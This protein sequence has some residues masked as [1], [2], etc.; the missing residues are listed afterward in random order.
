MGQE[1]ESFN[2]LCQLTTE[3]F[4]QFGAR[5]AAFKAAC[6]QR[7]DLAAD[8]IYPSGERVILRAEGASGSQ[9]PQQPDEERLARTFEQEMKAAESNPLSRA[10]QRAADAM[11]R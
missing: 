4:P 2:A 11:Q 1:N 10:C 3:L 8:A 9:Q 6:K 5:P 7:P